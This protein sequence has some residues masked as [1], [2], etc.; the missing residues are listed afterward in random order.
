MASKRKRKRKL[1]PFTKVLLV[2]IPCFAIVGIVYG[3][4]SNRVKLPMLN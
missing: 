4:D 1:K 3:I 2:L